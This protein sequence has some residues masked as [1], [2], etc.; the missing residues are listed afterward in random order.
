LTVNGGAV[1]TVKSFTADGLF[2]GQPPAFFTLA[3]KLA[4]AADSVKRSV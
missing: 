4:A 3:M 2:K 1:A